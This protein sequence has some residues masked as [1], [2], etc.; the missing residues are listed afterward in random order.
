MI[1]GRL[2]LK[3]LCLSGPSESERGPNRWPTS[4]W[5]HPIFGTLGSDLSLTSFL[6]WLIPGTSLRLLCLVVVWHTFASWRAVLASGWCFT[7]SQGMS[8]AEV[9]AVGWPLTLARRFIIPANVISNGE[10]SDQLPG[11]PLIPV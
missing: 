11:G 4:L 3:S 10:S 1:G 6:P 9:R 5:L 7:I 8:S 2:S